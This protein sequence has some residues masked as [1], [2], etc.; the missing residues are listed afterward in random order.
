MSDHDD[1]Q[2]AIVRSAAEVQRAHDRLVAIVTGDVDVGLG[3]TELNYAVCN[4]DVLCWLLGHE[5]NQTFHNNLQLI[6]EQFT[7][8]G[9]QEKKA[10][11][12]MTAAEWLARKESP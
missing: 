6:D 9:I 4:L 10:P 11:F 2:P 1:K 7:A 8:R 3:P 5:H 12:P